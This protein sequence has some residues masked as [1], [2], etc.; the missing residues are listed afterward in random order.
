MELRI[1]ELRANNESNGENNKNFEADWK[2]KKKKLDHDNI[3][4]RLEANIGGKKK[5]ESST[6]KLKNY[7]S[8]NFKTLGSLDFYK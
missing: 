6:I 2:K 7:K 3:N 5:K 1:L 8:V 4:W